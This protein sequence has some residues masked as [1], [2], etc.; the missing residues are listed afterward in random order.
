MDKKGLISIAISG[1]LK[2]RVCEDKNKVGKIMEK[3]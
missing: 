3:L 2:L 1:L